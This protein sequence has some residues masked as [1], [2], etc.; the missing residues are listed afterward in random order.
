MYLVVDSDFIFGIWLLTPSKLHYCLFTFCPTSGQTD[1]KAQVVSPLVLVG[2]CTLSVS[3]APHPNHHIK[4]KPVSFSC[5]LKSLLDLLRSSPFKS[6]IVWVMNLFTPYWYVCQIITLDIWTKFGVGVHSS[7]AGDFTVGVVS[8]IFRRWPPPRGLS[9]LVLWLYCS[10]VS[11]HFELC[12]FMLHLLSPT[13]L[14]H[15]FFFS[16]GGWGYIYSLRVYLISGN[17]NQS[18]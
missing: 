16:V 2:S 6:L 3:L 18:K 1:K 8:R 13:S 4:P 10:L 5:S 14:C 17:K 9:S 7:S 12:Y 15:I 11:T